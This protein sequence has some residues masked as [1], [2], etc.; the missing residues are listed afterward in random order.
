MERYNLVSL[1]RFIVTSKYPWYFKVTDSRD[2]ILFQKDIETPGAATPRC[3]SLVTNVVRTN[4]EDP[5]ITAEFI[6]VEGLGHCYKITNIDLLQEVVVGSPRER[7]MIK[8][9]QMSI[10]GTCDNPKLGDVSDPSGS[11]CIKARSRN[12]LPLKTSSFFFTLDP[13]EEGKINE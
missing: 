7:D 2:I 12:R 1:K 4:T 5:L 9:A 11:I 6:D 3:C 8:Y 13:I 10:N